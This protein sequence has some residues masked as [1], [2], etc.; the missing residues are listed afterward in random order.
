[1]SGGPGPGRT[2]LDIEWTNQHGCGDGDLN[3]Q[4][5]LQYMCEDHREQDIGSN[6]IANRKRNG[7]ND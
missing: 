4:I 7:R 1:M 5:I 6:N 3:C 2:Y